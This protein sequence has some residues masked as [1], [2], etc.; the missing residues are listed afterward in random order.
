MGC[1][2]RLNTIIILSFGYYQKQSSSSD[3]LSVSEINQII[4]SNTSTFIE[5]EISQRAQNCSLDSYNQAVFINDVQSEATVNIS[6]CFYCANNKETTIEQIL[7]ND[8]IAIELEKDFVTLFGNATQSLFILNNS[9]NIGVDIQNAEGA[10]SESTTLDESDIF[11]VESKSNDNNGNDAVTVIFILLFLFLM[12]GGIGILIYAK[13]RKQKV[14]EQNYGDEGMQTI[15][16]SSNMFVG[17]GGNDMNVETKGQL[18]D[19]DDDE[20]DVDEIENY[21]MDATDIEI[22]NDLNLIKNEVHA[23]KG[24]MMDEDIDNIFIEGQNENETMGVV[25]EN[26]I[27]DDDNDYDIELMDNYQTMGALPNDQQNDYGTN[28]FIE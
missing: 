22:V 4:E 14:D 24:Q 13:H 27:D 6:A 28:G 2:D 26:V 9:I 19:F 20:D 3:D 18:S 16:S 12:V 8:A 11:D 7:I 1:V 5:T 21:K 23:T 17:E 10:V 15:A 25:P